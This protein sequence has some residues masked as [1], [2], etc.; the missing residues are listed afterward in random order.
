MKTFQLIG[1][2]TAIVDDEDFAE[3]SR[4]KWAVHRYGGSHYA[5]A[6]PTVDGRR[7]FVF[8]H[9][10]VC[11]A[12]RPTHRNGNTLD[13]RRANLATKDGRPRLSTIRKGALAE[14]AVIKD[15]YERGF[16]VLQPFDGHCPYDLVIA[17][18]RHLLRRLQVK[19]RS[20]SGPCIELALRR[21]HTNGAGAQVKPIVLAHLDGIAIFCPEN[22]RV[23]YLP[24]DRLR[25]GSSV[26]VRVGDITLGD[27]TIL[28]SRVSKMVYPAKTGPENTQQVVDI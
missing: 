1:D 3:V 12:S 18:E 24:V 7:Q 10:L 2:R 11:G 27:P 16:T 25:E 9:A 15:L 26:R 17:D 20:A 19:Y 28:Y 4:Y 8:M 22:E 5:A 6:R 23:Y 13:N 21:V 14:A